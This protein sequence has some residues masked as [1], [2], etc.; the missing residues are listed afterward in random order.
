MKITR[1]NTNFGSIAQKGWLLT[2]KD[3]LVAQQHTSNA[4][5][6]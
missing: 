2:V 5:G 6:M 1:E 4:G 3:S